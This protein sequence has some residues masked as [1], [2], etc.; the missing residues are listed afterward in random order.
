M[1]NDQYGKP[2]TLKYM[3]Q[4]YKKSNDV[5]DD[6]KKAL[7]LIIRNAAEKDPSYF[8]EAFK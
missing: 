8:K 2:E 7:L 6:S 5:A 1:V 3:E 4:L